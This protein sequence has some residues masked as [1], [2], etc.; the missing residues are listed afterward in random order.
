[1]FIYILITIDID[2]WDF[3][4][5]ILHLSFKFIKLILTYLSFFFLFFKYD[6]D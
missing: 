4:L 6:I 3:F 2:I 5:P 1:M